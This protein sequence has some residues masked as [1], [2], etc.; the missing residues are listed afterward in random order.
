[1][2][3]YAIIVEGVASTIWRVWPKGAHTATGTT[4]LPRRNSRHAEIRLS[5]SQAAEDL[6]RNRRYA[7]D[8][9]S[10]R[11]QRIEVA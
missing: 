4:I 6:V 7:R 3:A 8:N 1:M 2:K 5:R 11:F 10:I 9:R